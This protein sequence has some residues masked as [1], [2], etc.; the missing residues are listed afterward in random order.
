LRRASPSLRPVRTAHRTEAI[1]GVAL[2]PLF[3][4]P[5]RPPALRFGP[6]VVGFDGALLIPLRHQDHR[7]N[8]RLR[9]FGEGRFRDEFSGNGPSIGGR[10]GSVTERNGVRSPATV[11]GPVR[12][13]S[14]EKAFSRL[15]CPLH[16]DAER[17]IGGRLNS[18]PIPEPTL[19]RLAGYLHCLNDIE[20]ELEFIASE[21]L[22]RRTQCPAEL[23]R[24][25]LSYFG[26]FGR[27]GVGYNVT[28]LR[29]NIA[30]ILH[31]NQ[32]QNLILVGAGNLGRALISYPGWNQYHLVVAAAFDADPTKAGRKLD[33]VTIE[34]I[35]TLDRRV[36][37]LGVRLA[38]MTVPAPSA[39]SV[40]DL[41]IQAGIKGILNFAPTPLEAPSNVV[42]R[43]VSFITELA[44]LSYL[45]AEET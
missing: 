42:V 15:E 28:L 21:E 14:L 2:S 23:V 29:Q 3:V 30:R 4:S 1:D 31:L 36:K 43:N 25:D 41:L 10:S 44:A 40:A 26:E 33:N 20:P 18:R 9:R 35:S 12:F 24:R 32:R 34:D 27:R 37:E 11:P 17:A 5:P 22:G 7:S 38:I 13:E 45:A 6:R 19:R 8:S 16:D 39:Q